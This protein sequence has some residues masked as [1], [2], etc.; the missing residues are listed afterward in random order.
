MEYNNLYGW[1]M[2]QKRPVNKFEW[3]EDTS[4][5]NEDFIENYNEKIDKDIFSKLIFIIQQNVMNFIMICLF[6]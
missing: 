3:I 5:F 2:S 1:V 6:Y 4:Q